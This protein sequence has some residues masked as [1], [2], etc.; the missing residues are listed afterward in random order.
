LANTRQYH[1][2]AYRPTDRV[3]ADRVAV[4]DLA[5]PAEVRGWSATT[6]L[7]WGDFV[8]L[9]SNA[10]SIN[11]STVGRI[12]HLAVALDT[13]RFNWGS[14]LVAG[15]THI[16]FDTG[17]TNPIVDPLAFSLR[18][19]RHHPDQEPSLQPMGRHLQRRGRC[20]SH[21][22]PTRPPHGVIA[23]NGGFHRLTRGKP[24]QDSTKSWDPPAGPHDGHLDFLCSNGLLLQESFTFPGVRM[25]NETRTGA[26]YN[27][28]GNLVAAQLPDIDWAADYRS[29]AETLY[30]WTEAAAISTLNWYLTEKKSKAR[31]SRTLRVFSVV[32][33][34]AGTLAPLIS[35]G[36][37]NTQ[38]AFWGYPV[39]GLGAASIGL[40]RA[41]GFS[42]SWMRYL[43]AAAALQKML[44]EYQLNWAGLTGSWTGS[45]PHVNQMH[46][47]IKEITRFAAKLSLLVA[48]ETENWITDFRG[49][50]SR[51][52]AEAA[53]M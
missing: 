8:C 14:E 26:R 9:A 49:H 41:F 50:V 16:P 15:H 37:N 2:I 42:S 39:L 18:G 27:N 11:L 4:I 13:V 34:T 21:R 33:I 45:A 51:L 23:L 31:W 5:P 52:E 1:T 35:V 10:C 24:R 17:A 6:Q 53:H 32:F 29:T 43:G 46:E 12:V 25:S 38:Y 47:A 30:R 36:T 3:K 40:D 48:D 7:P 19:R 44:I 28:D 20:R 22:R